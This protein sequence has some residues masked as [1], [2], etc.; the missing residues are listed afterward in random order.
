MLWV[1]IRARGRIDEDW[2]TWFGG[3]TIAYTPQDE[4]ILAGVVADQPELYG[5]LAR[6]RDLGLSLLAVSC[7]ES[8][9]AAPI[10]PH[11]LER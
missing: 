3:L 9:N 5:L 8:G 7:T 2:S 10:S 11:S 6:L 4:T 1:E